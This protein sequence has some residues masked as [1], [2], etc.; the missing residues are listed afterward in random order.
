MAHLSFLFY[1]VVKKGMYSYQPINNM[2]VQQ[3]EIIQSIKQPITLNQN[4]DAFER[5][6][7]SLPKT[8]YEYS[9]QYGKAPL[10]W[11]EL[12]VGAATSIHIPSSS[13]VVLHTNISRTVNQVKL[14]GYGDAENGIFFGQDDIGLF[15][16]LRS[17]SSGVVN[18]TRKFYQT[19]W[20]IDKLDGL[21]KS[22]Y[23]LNIMK[24]QIFICDLQWLGVG[25]VRCGFEYNGKLYHAHEF[26]NANIST[27]AYMT[28]A[29]LP[30]HVS[31]SDTATS[32]IRQT[33]TYWKY[34]PGKSLQ[35][36]ASFNFYNKNT[37]YLEQICATVI[38][39]GNGDTETYYQ[40]GISRGITERT[41]TT[42]QNLISCRAKLLL[43]GITNRSINF[44]QS[45]ELIITDAGT[46]Y[47]ELVYG[48]TL[49]GTP[50][51]I[52]CG[53]NIGCE[54]DISGTTV[55]NG[56][57]VAC[58]YA[59]GTTTNKQAYDISAVAKYPMTLKIDGTHGAMLTLCATVL[60]GS[61][62][63]LASMIIQSFN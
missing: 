34:H 53:I 12:I 59:S 32:I 63:M 6:R 48:C 39:E 57:V 50:A 11:D 8:N 25:R 30:L 38:T 14:I 60:S 4:L 35:F 49:G 36:M 61:S 9:F 23:A 21:G 33:F 29:N 22:A 42:R 51:W 55:T 20:N 31:I 13:T 5:L 40:V 18:D 10:I 17:K 16:L 47:W 45:F 58:G 56:D 28:S 24:T 1:N 44:Q 2:I 37:E 19:D 46:I 52:D 41:I 62:K 54:Y 26:N 15:F 43:N 27:L 7:V 3:E